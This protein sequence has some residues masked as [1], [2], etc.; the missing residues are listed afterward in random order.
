MPGEDQ[1]EAE[2]ADLGRHLE[3]QVGPHSPRAVAMMTRGVNIL[4]ARQV[5]LLCVVSVEVALNRGHASLGQ[6]QVGAR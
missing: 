4:L 1:V 6:G 2:L 3:R 5:P